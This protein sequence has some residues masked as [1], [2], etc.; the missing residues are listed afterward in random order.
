MVTGGLRDSVVDNFRKW[1][2]RQSG[3]RRSGYVRSAHRPPSTQSVTFQS[4]VDTESDKIACKLQVG[5][6][7]EFTVCATSRPLDPVFT[8][9]CLN[10]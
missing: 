2:A 6:A 9:F 8:G 7:L 4:V 5:G 3:R 1:S 10:I